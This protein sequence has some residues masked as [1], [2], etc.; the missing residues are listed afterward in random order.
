M[1]PARTRVVPA[2][3]RD[4]DNLVPSFAAGGRRLSPLE[5]VGPFHA[6]LSEA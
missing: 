6:Q 5:T 4:E 2:A 1:R 3:R